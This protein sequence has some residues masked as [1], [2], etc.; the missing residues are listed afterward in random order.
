MTCVLHLSMRWEHLSSYFRSNFPH[1]VSVLYNLVHCSGVQDNQCVHGMLWSTG[2]P[3]CACMECC[4]VVAIFNLQSQFYTQIASCLVNWRWGQLQ[5]FNLLPPHTHTQHPHHPHTHSTL[6]AHTH[7]TL[8][9]HTHTQHLHR[10]LFSVPGKFLLVRQHNSTV[11]RVS[12]T[13]LL[14]AGGVLVDSLCPLLPFKLAITSCSSTH[15][16]QT[17]GP[18]LALW[19]LAWAQ[20]SLSASSHHLQKVLYSNC[21]PIMI[22]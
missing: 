20:T 17:Q 6:T 1:K 10:P 9:A 7:N 22:I 2:Q 5:Y 11:S 13:S 14:Y 16:L 8:T 18:T 3:V 15:C 12:V 19:P 21:Q 4:G